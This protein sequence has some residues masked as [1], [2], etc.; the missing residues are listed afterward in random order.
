[1]NKKNVIIK[2]NHKFENQISLEGKK[3][4]KIVSS[5]SPL[6]FIRLLKNAD[7]KVNPRTATVNPVVKSIEET[8]SVS[9]ELY[10]FKT[11]GLLISTQNCEL[12]ERNR[13]KLSFNDAQTE[14]VMDGGH[15]AFAI[16]RFI[17]KKLFGECRFKEWK[18]LKTFWDDEGNY[19]D[20]EK[21]YKVYPSPEEFKFSIPIE[22]I[23]PSDE[24]EEALKR[25]T[26]RRS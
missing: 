11:K 9:P 14:G 18:E 16:G 5:I 7:N 8:L 15:N 12:L 19:T 6:D 25:T 21:R 10:F 20:I 3:I 23:T 26:N 4:S 24:T 2:L 1:M 22:I 13:V 17:Y